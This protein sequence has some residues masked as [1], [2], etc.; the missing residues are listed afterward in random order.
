[1]AG[2]ARD[3]VNHKYYKDIRNK[4]AMEKLLFDE[5]KKAPSK[6]EN[7]LVNLVI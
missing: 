5:K 2:F 7:N 4:E 6:Y 3:V 1:M